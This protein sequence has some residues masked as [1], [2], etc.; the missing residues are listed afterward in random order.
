VHMVLPTSSVPVPAGQSVHEVLFARMENVLR[1]HGNGSVALVVGHC[2][3]GGQRSV[4]VAVTT[5]VIVIN[6]TIAA[7]W[8]MIVKIEF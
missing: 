4:S 1:G 8:N 2:H 5:T 6:S 3:P 7:V